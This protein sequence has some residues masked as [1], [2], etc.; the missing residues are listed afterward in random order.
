H[1]RPSAGSAI[2][3]FSSSATPDAS[4]P[5]MASKRQYCSTRGT[6]AGMSGGRAVLTSMESMAPI[7][8]TIRQPEGDDRAAAGAVGDAQPA[9]VRLD[10]LAAQ[11]Q[12]Q[13]RA[14]RLGG[15]ERHQRV[16]QRLG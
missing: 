10:D 11:G 16:L 2:T 4:K 15:V 9:A 13:A 1:T 7:L 3:R 14:A 8:T 6:S 5:S 12:A